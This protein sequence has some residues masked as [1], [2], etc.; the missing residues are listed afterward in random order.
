P[1]P[2]WRHNARLTWSPDRST[3]L[4]LAWRYIGPTAL[5]TTSSNSFLNGSPDPIDARLPA[6]NYFDLTASFTVNDNLSLRLGATNLFDKNPP[7]IDTNL[8]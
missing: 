3:S 6:Y 8:L 7:A 1:Q 4:S 5:S 2:E